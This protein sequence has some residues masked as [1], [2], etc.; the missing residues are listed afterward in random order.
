MQAVGGCWLLGATLYGVGGPV[1]GRAAAAGWGRPHAQRCPAAQARVGRQ[2]GGRSAVGRGG[3]RRGWGRTR[4]QAADDGER[5]ERSEAPQQRAQLADFGGQRAAVVSP[6]RGGVSA[7]GG[8]GGAGVRAERPAAVAA[9]RARGVH[10]ADDE[11][12]GPRV[13]GAVGRGLSNWI[14]GGSA[15]CPFPPPPSPPRAPRLT[16]RSK[17]TPS[18]ASAASMLR[19]RALK[20]ARCPPEE[21]DATPA[22]RSRQRTDGAITIRPAEAAR[23]RGRG[24]DSAPHAGRGGGNAAG[25][26]ECLPSSV[27]LPELRAAGAGGL[28]RSLGD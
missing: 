25:L 14:A 24:A 20:A 15:T 22:S 28:R 8:Q 27:P 10:A 4:L 17:C 11:L 18:A 16:W 26:F 5:V 7:V 21:A 3:W 9:V 6:V 19:R 12:R 13:G 1:H 23:A 2:V